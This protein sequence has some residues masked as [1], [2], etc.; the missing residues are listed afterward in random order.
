M[1]DERVRPSRDAVLMRVAQAFADRGTC[2]R[3]PVGAVFSR[4]GRVL[5][6]GYNGPPSGAPECAHGDDEPCADAIHAE[7]NAI[8]WAAREGIRLDGAELHVTHSPCPVCARL[9]VQAG[10]RK[11]TYLIEYR[12]P[13]A[14]EYLRSAGLEVAPLALDG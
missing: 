14:I 5:I 6:T 13:D 4:G 7:A 9:I 8:A 2:S 12:I 10:V 3:L 11:V 1:G